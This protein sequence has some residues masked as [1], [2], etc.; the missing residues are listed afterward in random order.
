MELVLGFFFACNMGSGFAILET[1]SS[2]ETQHPVIFHR[3]LASLGP[4]QHGIDRNAVGSERA[5]QFHKLV[6]QV[7]YIFVSFSLELDFRHLESCS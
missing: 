7:L 6:L 2:E 4:Y 3:K 5:D 1:F